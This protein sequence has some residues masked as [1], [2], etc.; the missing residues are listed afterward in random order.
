MDLI[1]GLSGDERTERNVMPTVGRINSLPV[2]HLS[3]YALSL[4]EGSVLYRQAERG[5]FTML[6]DDVAAELY[7][8][9]SAALRESGFS[10]YEISNFARNGMESEHNNLYWDRK[11]YVGMGPAAHSY[12]GASVRRWN[13]ANLKKYI[14]GVRNGNYYEQEFLSAEDRYNETVMTCLRR[15]KGMTADILA[16]GTVA[17]YWAQVRDRA[18]GYAA[19]GHAEYDGMGFRLTE[20]G[21]LV[22]DSIFREL[23]VDA[24]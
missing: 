21:W 13:V 12:D 8:E 17:P 9:Y 11:P 2:S 4:E 16:S 14:E 7:L 22:S 23:F 24:E 3:L 19:S 15:E 5:R 10:H 20:E 1:I 6:P 18:A